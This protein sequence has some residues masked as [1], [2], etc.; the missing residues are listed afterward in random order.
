MKVEENITDPVVI[1]ERHKNA[2]YGM[3]EFT[4]PVYAPFKVINAKTFDHISFGWAKDVMTVPE[5]ASHHLI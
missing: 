5:I 2:H 3:D 4:A 1:G